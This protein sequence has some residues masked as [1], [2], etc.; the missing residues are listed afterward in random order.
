MMMTAPIRYWL[1]QSR[2]YNKQ[3]RSASMKMWN[4]DISIEPYREIS[5]RLEAQS[6]KEAITLALEQIDLEENELLHSMHAHIG[7]PYD[8][9]GV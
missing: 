4:V 8:Q 9:E 7:R 1:K 3:R 2:N 5:L 6:S